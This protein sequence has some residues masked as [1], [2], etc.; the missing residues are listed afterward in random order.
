MRIV[1]V[2]NPIVP[3]PIVAN[4]V[5]DVPSHV[6]I[7]RIEP[8]RIFAVPLTKIGIVPADEVVLETG[9]VV[10]LLAAVTENEVDGCVGF[11]N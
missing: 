8:L 6:F 9:G 10:E 7:S 1:D 3:Q 2:G 4:R 11:G 5:T